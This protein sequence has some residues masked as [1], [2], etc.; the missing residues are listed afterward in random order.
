[1]RDEKQMAIKRENMSRQWHGGIL[2][3][4]TASLF[5]HSQNENK[6]EK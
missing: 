5:I 2:S 6:L 4:A 3:Y 1:M